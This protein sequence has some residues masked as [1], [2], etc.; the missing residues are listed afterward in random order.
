MLAFVCWFAQ[1][2]FLNGSG[3]PG[4]PTTLPLQYVDVTTEGLYLMV[5][6]GR[7]SVEPPHWRRS[8]SGKLVQ[9]GQQQLVMPPAARANSTYSVAFG[10]A[11]TD[12]ATLRQRGPADAVRIDHRLDAYFQSNGAIVYTRLITLQELAPAAVQCQ[13]TLW[14]DKAGN[15]GCFRSF[16]YRHMVITAAVLATAQTFNQTEAEKFLR[17]FKPL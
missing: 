16:Y 15:M 11:D 5:F 17:S 2:C 10:A 13:Q 12:P 6:P 8:P 1:L 14:R 4:S 7:P 9:L 3:Q